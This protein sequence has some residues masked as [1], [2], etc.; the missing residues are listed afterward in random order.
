MIKYK[1]SDQIQENKT[2]Q[3]KT[4]YGGL[5]AQVF[6]WKQNKTEPKDQSIN[7]KVSLRVYTCI[8][9]TQ[10]CLLLFSDASMTAKLGR[11]GRLF[12]FYQLISLILKTENKEEK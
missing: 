6:C 5:M 3:K 1:N 2:T 11:T 9:K 4:T 10:N 8:F 12:C 7:G